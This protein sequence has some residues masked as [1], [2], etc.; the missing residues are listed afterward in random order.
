MLRFHR[1]LSNFLY[2]CKGFKFSSVIQ[3]MRSYCK[4]NCFLL[5]YA[6]D[7]TDKKSTNFSFIIPF[8]SQDR[9]ISIFTRK[10]LDIGLIT[11]I[12]AVTTRCTA[13][14]TAAKS[15]RPLWSW[16][17]RKRQSWW[18]YCGKRPWKQRYH[19]SLYWGQRSLYLEN[20][21]RYKIL[22]L[23]LFA[24]TCFLAL[25]SDLFMVYI[26][27]AIDIAFVWRLLVH[28]A[29]LYGLYVV[30]KSPK[31]FPPSGKFKVTQKAA[32]PV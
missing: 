27:H 24:Q 21:R 14:D 18:A 32:F 6:N 10:F 12:V 29:C 22:L 31:R 11:Y 19:F 4:I 20:N 15:S 17:M 28:Y 26:A 2:V 7:C 23:N 9:I 1:D 3:G 30:Y 5:H 13:I 8:L 25:Y 16:E